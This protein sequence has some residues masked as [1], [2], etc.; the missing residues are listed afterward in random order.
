MG[1][2]SAL[3]VLSVGSCACIF[4]FGVKIFRAMPWTDLHS[5]AGD[6]DTAEIERLIAASANIEARDAAGENRHQ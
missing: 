5:A 4:A 1:F 2:P 3:P 6:N